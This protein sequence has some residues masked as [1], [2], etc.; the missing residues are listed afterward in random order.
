MSSIELLPPSSSRPSHNY[1]QS[2]SERSVSRDAT[3]K[4]RRG[5]LKKPLSDRLWSVPIQMMTFVFIGFAGALAHY[6]CER[7]SDIG[8]EKLI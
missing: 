4:D 5:W 7:N 2:S 6:L 8:S 3:A 1:L